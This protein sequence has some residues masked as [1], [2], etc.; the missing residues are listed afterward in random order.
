MM[1]SRRRLKY[2]I[3]CCSCLNLSLNQQSLVV[4]EEN[5]LRTF[6]SCIPFFFLF[7]FH[8]SLSV[9]VSLSVPLCHSPPLSSSSQLSVVERPFHK[10]RHNILFCLLRSWNDAI[11]TSSCHSHVFVFV[12]VVTILHANFQNFFKSLFHFVSG[13]SHFKYQDKN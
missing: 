6:L 13:K 4:R 9:S 7:S 1:D 10:K 3:H 8:L 5:P 12:Q 2:I 11:S